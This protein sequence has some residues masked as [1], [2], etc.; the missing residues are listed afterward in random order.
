[1]RRAVAGP[2][3]PAGHA[4]PARDLERNDD[5]V[6]RGNGGDGAANLLDH[7]NGLMPEGI[8]AGE[9]VGAAQYGDIDVTCRHRQGPQ[10]LGVE[11]GLGDEDGGD[12]QGHVAGHG[13]LFES[14][15][16]PKGARYRVMETFPLLGEI[17]GEAAE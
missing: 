16:S 10:P 13:V 11:L 12:R 2:P 8:R 4:C 1:M 3:R 6:A 17:T 7:G 9:R 14:K 15:L 5:E